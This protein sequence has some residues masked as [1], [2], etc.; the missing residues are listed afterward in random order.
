MSS[1]CSMTQ[2]TFH[3]C[4]LLLAP[5][6][7]RP[8]FCPRP[9]P[10]NHQSTEPALCSKGWGKGGG[11]DGGVTFPPPGA[12]LTPLHNL[13][14]CPQR[15]T[16]LLDILTVNVLAHTQRMQKLRAKNSWKEQTHTH[17][18]LILPAFRHVLL[19]ISQQKEISHDLWPNGPHPAL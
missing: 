12:A 7:R 17:T 13:H 8:V 5:G 6:V 1:L 19:N 10:V 14:S 2:L 16:S 3:L 9:R 18:L 11:G 4:I 15:N